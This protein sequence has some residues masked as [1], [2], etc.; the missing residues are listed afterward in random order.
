VFSLTK[1]ACVNDVLHSVDAGGTK[2]PTVQV[3]SRSPT[4]R[5][6]GGGTQMS[7]HDGVDEHHVAV[8]AA[9]KRARDAVAALA[10][11]SPTFMDGMRSALQQAERR[12]CS[13]SREEGGRGGMN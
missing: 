3:V 10:E 8:A 13:S 12:R 7:A 5:R 4:S 9:L 11:P 6:R 1:C 2:L